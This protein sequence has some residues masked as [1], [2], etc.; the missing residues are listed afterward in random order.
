MLAM[1]VRLFADADD[2][3]AIESIEDRDIVEAFRKRKKRAAA[4]G[5]NA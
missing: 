1:C 5:A 3:E 4:A 2:D